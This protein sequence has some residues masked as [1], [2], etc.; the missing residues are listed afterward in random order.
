[1]ARWPNGAP[2]ATLRALEL[3]VGAGRALC[4]AARQA[5]AQ[6]GPPA[7]CFTKV[8]FSDQ[9]LEPHLPVDTTMGTRAKNLSARPTAEKC[10]KCGSWDFFF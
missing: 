2:T 4:A 1:M 3:V 8:A 7:P 5:A 9:N 10:G 6:C